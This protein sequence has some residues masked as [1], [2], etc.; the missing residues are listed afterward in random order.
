M[1]HLASH[2]RS[3]A[4]TGNPPTAELIEKADELDK[5]IDTRFWGTELVLAHG[6]GRGSCGRRSRRADA[7]VKYSSPYLA[8]YR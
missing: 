8:G 3:L 2:M 1:G 7:L 4:A 6:C 5:L